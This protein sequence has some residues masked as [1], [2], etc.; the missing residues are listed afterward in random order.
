MSL[1]WPG[2]VGGAEAREGEDAL[3]AVWASV[4]VTLTGRGE[5]GCREGKCSSQG[6]QRDPWQDAKG[7]AH[8]SNLD[9]VALGPPVAEK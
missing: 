6:T 7:R 8:R 5:P 9:L 1:Q 3:R 4:R 2:E